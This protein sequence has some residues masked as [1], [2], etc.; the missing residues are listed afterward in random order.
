MSKGMFCFSYLKS[1]GLKWEKYIS[2]LFCAI[3]GGVLIVQG[4][5]HILSWLILHRS[6]VGHRIFA[7]LQEILWYNCSPV[8][9]LSAQWLYRGAEGAL[10]Q[11]DLSHELYLPGLLQPKPVSPRQVSAGPCLCRKHSC[12]SASVSCGSHCSFPLVLV[13]TRFCFMHWSSNTLA[14]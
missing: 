3:T 8:C 10:C 4:F 1:N 12:R 2:Y 11:E 13:C 7:I 14:T 5:V 9:G 6:V